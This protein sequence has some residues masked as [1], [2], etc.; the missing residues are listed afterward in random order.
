MSVEKQTSLQSTDVPDNGSQPLTSLASTPPRKKQYCG[1]SME[2]LSFKTGVVQSGQTL[3][4]LLNPHGIS[5]AAIFQ[6]AKTSKPVFDVRRIKAGNTYSLI[7]SPEEEGRVKYFI[8]NQS[9]INYVVFDFGNPIQVYKGK[10]QVEI[11][12]RTLSGTITS[13]LWN[14][15]RD[16]GMSQELLYALGDIFASTMDF[17]HLHKGDEFM[18]TFEEKFVSNKCVATGRIKAARLTCCNKIFQAFGYE[19]NDRINYYDEQGNSL[20]KSFLK[21]PLKYSRISSKFSKRRL[22]PI[23]QKYMPHPGI[24]YAAPRGTPVRSVGDGIVIF[25]GYSKG[26]GNYIK[27]N[28]AGVGVSEY[29]HLSKFHVRIRKNQKVE[30]G[31]IIGYVGST[32]YAT[33]PHLDLRFKKNGKYVDY[34]KMNLPSGKSLANPHK[35]IFLKQVAGIKQQWEDTPRLSLNHGTKTLD[36]TSKGE[37]R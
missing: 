9:A 20:E 1:I 25:K 26:A 31:Q 4:H 10:K 7:S 22:H 5:N 8:Y 13:S 16:S 37:K 29:M 6:A 30:K 15:A 11:K 18:I 28:H 2:G 19:V 34:T 27:I 12:T 24:D 3:A 21:S 17:R 33:G 23:K 32:G 14:A 35:E 36:V